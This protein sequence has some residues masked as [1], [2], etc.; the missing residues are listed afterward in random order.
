MLR[1]ITIG[2]VYIQQGTENYVYIKMDLRF[3]FKFNREV[4]TIL[5]FKKGT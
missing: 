4:N 5:R 2:F 1:R 3:L